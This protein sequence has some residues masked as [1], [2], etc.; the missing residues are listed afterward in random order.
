MLRYTAWA[1]HRDMLDTPVMMPLGERHVLRKH[2]HRSTRATEET[3]PMCCEATTDLRRRPCPRPSQGQGARG[4]RGGRRR[5]GRGERRGGR[6]P[7]GMGRDRSRCR[8]PGGGPYRALRARRRRSTAS[9]TTTSP[10]S[11]I[12]SPPSPL[13]APPP[14]PREPT[15]ATLRNHSSRHDSLIRLIPVS[16]GFGDAFDDSS[17]TCMPNA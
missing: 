3:A 7:G 5:G 6:A 12:V 8:G 1:H 17:G 9:S 11:T 10:S 16:F 14:Q 2:H 13:R 15:A 4:D